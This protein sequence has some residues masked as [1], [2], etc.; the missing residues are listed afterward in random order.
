M[1]ITIGILREMAG[2]EVIGKEELAELSDVFARGGVLFR[3]SFESL[4]N[5]CFKVEEFLSANDLT[6]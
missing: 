6:A 3:H 5:G 4:R 2:F 1:N